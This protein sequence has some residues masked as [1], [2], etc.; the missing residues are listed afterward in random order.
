MVRFEVAFNTEQI[1]TLRNMIVG[2]FL[3]ITTILEAITAE[4]TR[5]TMAR[6]SPTSSKIYKCRFTSR[7]LWGHEI[8][9]VSESSL[10]S[11]LRIRLLCKKSFKLDTILPAALMDGESVFAQISKN[12]KGSP[13]ILTL[14]IWAWYIT[15]VF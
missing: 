5:A 9:D 10:H 3:V 6:E 11:L 15:L 14:L 7:A 1:S 4:F 13:N 12:I 8:L 2:A